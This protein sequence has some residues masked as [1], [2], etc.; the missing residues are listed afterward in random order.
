M[1]KI[2]MWRFRHWLTKSLNCLDLILRVKVED[3]CKAN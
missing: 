1:Q 3:E 2:H